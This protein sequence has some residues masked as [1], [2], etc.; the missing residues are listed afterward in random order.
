MT[1]AAT[2]RFVRLRAKSRC[3]YCLMYE[4]DEP[5]FAFHL[6]HIIA[7]KHGGTDDLENLAWRCHACNEAKGPNLASVDPV[8]GNIVRLFHPRTQQWTRHFAW[9]GASIVGRTQVGRATVHAL[10]MNATHRQALRILLIQLGTF[11]PK[12]K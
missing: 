5:F 1:T 4:D 6:E 3:E 9:T 7:K 11:P 8:T 12:Y 2:R 10:D